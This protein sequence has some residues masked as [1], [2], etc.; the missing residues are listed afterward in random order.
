MLHMQHQP[1]ACTSDLGDGS[2]VTCIII[3]I[4]NG[5]QSASLSR[6]DFKI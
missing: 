2:H 6:I 1:E 5:C 3:E 4:Q